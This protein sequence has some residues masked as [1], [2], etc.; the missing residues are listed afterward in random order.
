MDKDTSRTSGN[1]TEVGLNQPLS[2]IF[3]RMSAVPDDHPQP[4]PPLRKSQ[5]G[6]LT[7]ADIERP[8]ATQRRV[9][10]RLRGGAHVRA[11]G[12]GQRPQQGLAGGTAADLATVEENFAV[13]AQRRADGRQLVVVVVEA[14]GVETAVA[15]VQAAFAAVRE[16]V[17]GDESGGA[18]QM[19]GDLRQR[20]AAP[21]EQAMRR[22]RRQRVDQALMIGDAGIDENDRRG[23]GGTG[24][25]DSVLSESDE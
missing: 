13:I 24:G 6:V 19:G 25:H 12:C 14:V 9:P 1:A 15:Q 7:F 23:M 2:P 21:V 11:G 4:S 22:S 5:R 18:P 20:V 16:E 8:G 17:Q 10:D 3:T